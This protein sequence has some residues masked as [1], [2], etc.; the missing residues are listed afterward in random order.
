MRK[1]LLIILIPAII[2]VAAVSSCGGTSGGSGQAVLSPEPDE[3]R[4]FSLD[5][6][7]MSGYKKVFGHASVPGGAGGQTCSETW[8]NKDGE[9]IEIRYQVCHSPENADTILAYYRDDI[10]KGG[11]S[12]EDLEPPIG[13]RSWKAAGDRHELAFRKGSVIIRVTGKDDSTCRS[14]S[15]SVLSRLEKAGY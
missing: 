11:R 8:R 15:E 9:K 10:S 6:N 14:I 13:D 12:P 4:A 7:D 3:I 5:E 1:Y 2:I